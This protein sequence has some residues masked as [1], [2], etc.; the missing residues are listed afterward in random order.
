[1]LR[2]LRSI[3][4]RARRVPGSRTHLGLILCRFLVSW[5]KFRLRRPWDVRKPLV[6]ISLIEHM[7]DIVAA[8][9]VARF[10]RAKYPTGRIVWCLRD[11]YAD[12]VQCTRAVDELYVVQCLTE[13]M[14]LRDSGVFDVCID[15][16]IHDRV[17]R[18]C[19]LPL[20]AEA[21]R[22]RITSKNYYHFGNL[23]AA[24]CMSANIPIL[25]DGPRLSVPMHIKH[26]V[27]ALSLPPRF[28]VV[29][30]SAIEKIRNWSEP[31]WHQLVDR[32]LERLLEHSVVEVGLTSVAFAV[33]KARCISYCGKLS[34]LET[35][36]VIGRADLFIGI[37]S[38]PAHIANA[39]GTPGVVLLGRYLGFDHYLPYSG[40]YATGETATLIRAK[41]PASDI[42]VSDV[43]QAALERLEPHA[44]AS[45]HS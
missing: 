7:G 20:I 43:L 1:M 21:P 24:Q 29:H 22:Q 28:V 41:G 15:L 26:R 40:G 10:V 3:Y 19:Q 12:L 44:S 16:H 27:D 38:G 42:E 6:A 5:G 34:I 25:S 45:A 33:G 39:V 13:W 4:W 31:K 14:L 23:L 11:A 9:P 32:L 36:E 2:L 18:E 37:D 17:C 30:C 8:E 35:A